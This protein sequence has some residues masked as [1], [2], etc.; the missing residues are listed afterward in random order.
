MVPSALVQ[1]NGESLEENWAPLAPFVNA[2]SE[3]PQY[4]E[5]ASTLEKF[6]TAVACKSLGASHPARAFISIWERL[7]LS[8]KGLI[9]L[10]SCRVLVP[11]ALRQSVLL[12]LHIRQNG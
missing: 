12:R 8:E 1:S 5:L 3:D 9:L 10:D 2:A 11:R 6:P 7:S 4:K